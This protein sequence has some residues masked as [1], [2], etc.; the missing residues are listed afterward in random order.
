M[1]VVALHSSS[2]W[3]AIYFVVHYGLHNCKAKEVIE[4]NYQEGPTKPQ[5]ERLVLIY[6]Y[7][8]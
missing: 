3:G 6:N 7:F 2:T 5:V 4:N 8:L 1:V